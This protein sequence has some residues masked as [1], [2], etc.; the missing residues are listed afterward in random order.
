V[1]VALWGIRILKLWAAMGQLPMQLGEAI[2]SGIALDVRVDRRWSFRGWQLDLYLD[3]QNVY[4]RKNVSQYI[5][6]PR[7]GE[8]ESNDSL[9]I[10]P[11][12]GVNV[13]F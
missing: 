13:E 6:N 12:I 5:W 4:G 9:G 2:A 3:V 7:T 11:T 10:L 8:T 1:A